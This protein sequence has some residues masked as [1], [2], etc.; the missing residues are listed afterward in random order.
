METPKINSVPNSKIN[1]GKTPVAFS[2]GNNC[3]KTSNLSKKFT[4]STNKNAK[5][6]MIKINKK[7][8]KYL[9]GGKKPESIFR[10]VAREVH[11]NKGGSNQQMQYLEKLIKPVLE[12]VG[13]SMTPKKF[14]KFLPKP[15]NKS[16]SVISKALGGAMAPKK[17]NKNL[18]KVLN[19]APKSKGYT[20][21]K[22]AVGVGLAATVGKAAKTFKNSSKNKKTLTRTQTL[23]QAGAAGKK[24]V[25]ARK[26]LLS[27]VHLKYYKNQVKK[28]NPGAKG[29]QL[30]K[31]LDELIWQKIQNKSINDNAKNPNIAGKFAGR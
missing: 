1:T 10:L 3:V 13:K 23:E 27:E 22:A 5:P 28:N 2:T 21:K 30:T 7:V 4:F 17:K 15:N 12:G 18:T 11:P 20:D 29:R 31:L 8:Q 14:H 6:F 9:N 16:P 25:K 24:Q 19:K 26:G